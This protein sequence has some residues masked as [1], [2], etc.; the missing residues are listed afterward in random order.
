[1]ARPPKPT[2][3]L[4]LSGAFKNHPERLAKRAGEPVPDGK[5]GS[6]PRNWRA[7]KVNPGS[8][9][10][11]A[12]MAEVL[13]LQMLSKIWKEVSK[14]A[15]WLTSADR[16]AVEDICHLRLLARSG[17]IRPGE[18]NVLRALMNSCGLD[19]SGR[20]KIN[21]G[22]VGG[23]AAKAVDPRDAFAKQG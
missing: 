16:Y 13:R 7:K 17:V 1:M 4:Q 15:P 14:M 8:E 12:E 11:G 2:N 6:P 5:L 20:A 23:A 22:A 9:T 19:P 21:T 3:L 10:Y 18:R